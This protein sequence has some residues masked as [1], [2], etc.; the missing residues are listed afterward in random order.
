[1]DHDRIEPAVASIPGPRAGGVDR[2]P[3]STRRHFDPTYAF[4]WDLDGAAAGPF[5]IDVDGNVLLE[6][7]SQVRAAPLGYNRPDITA[8]LEAFDL[9]R[10]TNMAGRNI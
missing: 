10:P 6:F 3:R 2:L 7:T 1:M 4:V 8:G 9:P 5:S